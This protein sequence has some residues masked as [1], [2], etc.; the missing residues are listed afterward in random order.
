M[1]ILSESTVADRMMVGTRL[2]KAPRGLVWRAW[3][4]PEL[5]AQWWGPQGFA[6]TFQ[7]YDLRPGGEWLFVMRGPDGQDYKNRSNF[8][9]IAAP[10]RLKFDHASGPHFAV[11]A[12]FAEEVGGTQVRFAGLF[13]SVEEWERVKGYAIE[14]NRQTLDRLEE[15]VALQVQ[16]AFAFERTLNAPRD[17]VWK[18]WTKA[19]RLKQWW[20]PKGFGMRVASLDLRPEGL[21]HY[22][23]TTP[24]GQE[25]WGKFV[26]RD[27]VAPQRLVLVVSFSDAEVGVTRHP[28]SAAWP[29][30]VLN[31]ITLVEHEGRTTLTLRGVPIHAT[32][33]ECR[34]FEGGFES[35]RQGFNGTLDQ[36]DDHLRNHPN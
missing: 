6:N 11:A 20:G 5:L 36:L 15:L 27:I 1:A 17:R 31:E 12:T 25:F 4:E 24:E 33:E 22:A 3:T 18:A 29:L 23:M 14:G 34:T 7:T 21:F 19:E 2:F 30:E 9:E 10:E 16:S 26:Y 13:D 28:L 35:M 32:E 8:T